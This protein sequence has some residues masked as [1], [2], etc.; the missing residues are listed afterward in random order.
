MGSNEGQHRETMSALM[1]IKILLSAAL[2]VVALRQCRKPAWLP[3]RLFLAIMNSTHAGVTKWGLAHLPIEK[4][5]R[6]LDVGC[7]G[8]RTVRTLAGIATEGKVDGVDY[9]PTSVAAARSTNAEEIQSGR[10]AIQQASV[11]K[12]PFP[13]AAFDLVTAVETHY[14]WPDPAS[15]FREILR[16]LKPGGA[17]AIIAETYRGQKLDKLLALPMRALGARYLT[18]DE[19]R[20]LLTAAG[21]SSVTVDVDSGKGWICGVGRKPA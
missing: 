20:Q 21:F 2:V 7:G 13:D 6:I 12:L 1:A 10:V 5:F 9:S 18:V 4:D 11:S 14:Y 8:G 17:L 3:G 15:D 16:V 19:H